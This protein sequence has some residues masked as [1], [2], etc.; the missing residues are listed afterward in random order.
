MLYNYGKILSL[1]VVVCLSAMSACTPSSLI[2]ADGPVRVA[3]ALSDEDTK[4]VLEPES[5]FFSWEKDDKLA[6]WAYDGAGSSVFQAQP[7]T[8]LAR[9]NSNRKAY[10]TSVL[11]SA[12][13]EGEYSYYL[14][15]P[16]PESVSGTTAVFS[17]PSEQD[18]K[19]SGG[20]G[21][22]VSDPVVSGALHPF[23]ENIPVDETLS[24]NAR[25][26]HI[27]HYLR[28][29]VPEGCNVLGEPLKSIE[30]TM[31]QPVAGEVQVNVPDRSAS[32]SSG[33]NKIRLSMEDR[34]EENEYAAAGI[35]PPQS[36]YADGDYMNIRVYSEN[37]YSDL[38]PISLAGRDFQAGHITSVPLRITGIGQ[39]Y[40]VYFTFGSN[41]LGEE[42]QKI[43]VSLPNEITWKGE[44]TSEFVFSHEDGSTISPG[45]SFSFSTIEA[46]EFASLSSLTATVY[47]ESENAIVSETISFPAFGQSDTSCSFTLNCPYLLFEDF[48]TLEAFSSNDAY[49]SGFS[50]GSKTGVRLAN[51][52]KGWTAAR[53]GGEAGTA[54]RLAARRETSADYGSRCDS[55]LLT[56]I[57]E[58]HNVSLKLSFDYSMN[59]QEGGIVKNVGQ[60]VYVGWTTETGPLSSGS[61]SGTFPASF[62]INETTGS[63]TNIDKTYELVLDDMDSSKRLSIRTAP[64]HNWLGTN[65]TYW[66]YIDNIKVTITK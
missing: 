37:A 23:D 19:A 57:K 53:A 47:Y 28:F 3:F 4:T 42:V 56:G 17:L 58:G 64:E 29:Y 39:V 2:S 20:V 32:L 35:F 34:L 31:P 25:L 22:C 26:K 24:F 44:R 30:F 13:A 46:A 48:S 10:F 36:T 62:Y 27:L 14:A 65:G 45:E 49:E 60:T 8:L 41:N 51:V 50:T 55:P 63:Y 6:V 21:I 54:I 11:S 1:L 59:R 16:Y 7:F 61:K 38:D 15:Y 66:L 9:G 12:M 18:G 43:T 5:G 52:A 40:N 33:V